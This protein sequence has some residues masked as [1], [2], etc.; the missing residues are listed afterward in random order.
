[1]KDASG[2]TLH[3]AVGIGKDRNIYLVKRDAMGKFNAKGIF[4]KSFPER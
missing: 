1:M 4:I 2:N 3:L